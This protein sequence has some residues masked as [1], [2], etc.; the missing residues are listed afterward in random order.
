[1]RTYCIDTILHPPLWLQGFDGIMGEPGKQGKDGLKV[2]FEKVERTIKCFYLC[3]VGYIHIQ[4]LFFKGDRGPNDI[5]GIPGPRGDKV[6][7]RC[8]LFI[9]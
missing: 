8:T 7:P 4:V 1:M 5:P 6:G 9:N 3:V 2:G